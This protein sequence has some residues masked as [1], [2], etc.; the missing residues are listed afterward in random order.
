MKKTI[1]TM[2]AA[3]LLMGA[4]PATANADSFSLSLGGPVY[5][6]PAYQPVYPAPVYYEPVYPRPVYYP[7]YSPGYSFYYSNRDRYRHHRHKHW[8][9]PGRGRGHGHGHGRWH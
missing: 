3:L 9:H 5:A 6:P 4:L 1:L 2:G 8:D 7:A